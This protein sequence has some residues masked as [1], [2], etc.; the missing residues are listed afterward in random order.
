MKAKLARLEAQEQAFLAR[1]K[2]QDPGIPQLQTESKPLKRKKRQQ[3]EEEAT[4]TER[5]ADTEYPQHT[6]QSIRKSKKKR[7]LQDKNE[8]TTGGDEEEVTG[9]RG[10][11]ER[12]SREPTDSFPRKRKKKKRRHREEERL[13]VFGE[14]GGQG[15]V[16]G[17]RKGKAES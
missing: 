8:E 10:L 7:Q 9:T 1:L 15:D 6:A 12:K 11:G 2:G 4:A 16:G 14:G 5:N 17:L 3:K 13:G